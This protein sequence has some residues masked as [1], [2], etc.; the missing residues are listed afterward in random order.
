MDLYTTLPW[1]ALC[2]EV[3][4]LRIELREGRVVEFR[5]AAS[6]TCDSPC[7]SRSEANEKPPRKVARG[8]SFSELRGRAGRPNADRPALQRTNP[9]RAGRMNL[10][11]EL[12]MH[13]RDEL[14][15]AGAK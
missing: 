13:E 14:S 12:R 8:P 3:E 11:H 10:A 15:A 5:K 6:A 1:G 7:V 4:K 2:A 9:A